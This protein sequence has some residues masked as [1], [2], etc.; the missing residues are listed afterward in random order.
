VKRNGLPERIAT[1]RQRLGLSQRRFAVRI[2]VSRNI[3]LRYEGGHGRPRTDTLERIAQLGGVSVDWLLGGDRQ[4][5]AP[6]ERDPAWGEA[7]AW[8][9]QAWRDPGR[10]ETVV[11]VLK[12]LA[13]KPRSAG[14]R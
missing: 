4:V 6:P 1:V 11:G 5:A 13:V 12:A 9:R 8:L 10:R 3:V 14:P 7:V 2:G